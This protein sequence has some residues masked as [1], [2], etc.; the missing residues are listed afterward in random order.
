[1]AIHSKQIRVEEIYK[2]GNFKQFIL[3]KTEAKVLAKDQREW[4]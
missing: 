4:R 3:L 1:M 2:L